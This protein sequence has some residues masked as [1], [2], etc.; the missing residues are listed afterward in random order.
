[1]RKRLC[2][3]NSIAISG[4]EAAEITSEGTGMTPRPAPA[5]TLKKGFAF[6]TDP[7]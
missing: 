6:S 3:E 2:F 1:M 5:H 7:Y 4:Q